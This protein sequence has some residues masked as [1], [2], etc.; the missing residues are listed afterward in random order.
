MHDCTGVHPTDSTSPAA[1]VGYTR[2]APEETLLYQLVAQNFDGFVADNAARGGIL[3]W[4]VRREFDGFL[5]CGIL[6][7]GLCRLYCADCQRDRLIAFSCKG[8]SLCPSCGVRRMADGAAHLVD[9][10]LPKAPVRQWVLS[11]P[12]ALRFAV[13][14]DATLCGQVLALFIRAVQRRYRRRAKA[15]LGLASVRQAHTGAVT[16]IQRFSSSLGLN[17]HFHSLFVDGIYLERA[18]GTAQFRTVPPPSRRELQ[19]VTDEVCAAVQRLRGLDLDSV[20]FDA[21]RDRTAA[22]P[23]LAA[24]AGAAVRSR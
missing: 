2:R 23:L 21:C 18:D 22:E 13:G 4:F 5:R 11:L 6:D 17:L 10:V 24:C 16:A 20:Q 7:H 19:A 1:A 12:Y 9:R 3:P 8:R 14:F 15:Q